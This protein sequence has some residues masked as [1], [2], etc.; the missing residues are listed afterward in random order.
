[1]ADLPQPNLANLSLDSV[2]EMAKEALDSVLSKLGFKV[3]DK[4]LVPMIA[5]SLSNTFATKID[6]ISDESVT[7][8]MNPLAL[9]ILPK[10]L[11]KFLKPFEHPK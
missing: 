8:M 1:M 11:S 10:E 2:S 3:P 4:M 9:G 5:A 6:V 7:F